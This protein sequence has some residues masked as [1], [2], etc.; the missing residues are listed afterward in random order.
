MTDTALE[1]WAM[2]Q[3]A[4]T[5][6]EAAA[7]PVLYAESDDGDG[8]GADEIA[9]YLGAA[10]GPGAVTAYLSEVAATA[11]PDRRAHIVGW[12]DQLRM[13]DWF[14]GEGTMAIPAYV[15][16]IARQSDWPSEPA[17]RD[18][19]EDLVGTRGELRES[20]L[21]AIAEAPF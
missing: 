19:F 17:L 14:P 11:D 5:G 6:V 9:R 12:F 3:E 16:E 21:E 18:A 7:A 10:P 4:L 15:A 2:L 1:D 20:F 8:A 13:D